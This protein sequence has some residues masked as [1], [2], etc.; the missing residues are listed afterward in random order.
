MTQETSRQ[1]HATVDTTALEMIVLRAIDAF[2][3]IG[4]IS[5]DV[6]RYCGTGYAYSSITARFRALVD[7]GLIARTGQTRPGNSGCAQSIMVITERGRRLLNGKE[8][9]A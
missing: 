5:D 1:A 9:A 8:V 6:R 4:C 7:K 2:S 3:P